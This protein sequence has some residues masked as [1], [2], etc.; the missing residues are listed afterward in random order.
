MSGVVLIPLLI[1]IGAVLA[2]GVVAFVI[3]WGRVDTVTTI[4]NT[5]CTLEAKLCP[6]GSSVGR[7]PPLCDF[8]SCPTVNINTNTAANINTASGPT[9]S[10]ATAIEQAEQYD[11]QQ[12]CLVGWYQ[13]SFEFSGMSE[14]VRLF[15]GE[16]VLE[17]PYV[18]ASVQIPES[19][20]TCRTTELRQKICQGQVTAC[21]TFR[22]AAPNEFGFGHL[23]SYRY[24]LEGPP[25]SP[26]SNTIES[27]NRSDSEQNFN[28]N[29]ANTNASTNRNLSPQTNGNTGST[30]NTADGIVSIACE[31][32][33]DCL[34]IKKS[35]EYSVC[36]P[37]PFCPEYDDANF[38][39][40]NEESF[41]SVVQSAKDAREICSR[42]DC[43][44]YSP[45]SC[46]TTTNTTGIAAKCVSRVCQKVLP[47]AVQPQ[48]PPGY[49][50]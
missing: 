37:T 4:T 48:A 13:S 14:T 47:A 26:G 2:F 1:M 7:V 27:A 39:A 36:C 16:Y 8:A 17:G 44:Q 22:Y 50:Y 33:Q 34:L 18:W 42:V 32:D 10:V 43:P 38:I 19:Q 23:A 20:L 25:S 9:I 30:V 12:L 41:T 28:L 21:G 24:E 15:E 49:S 3:F 6:D 45:P 31:S 5:A 35:R 11:D 29:L 40:V 46:P